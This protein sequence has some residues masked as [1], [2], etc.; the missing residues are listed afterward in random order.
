MKEN[1][2]R[3]LEWVFKDEGGYAEREEEGGGAVNMGITYSVFKAWRLLHGK[4][5]PTW[6]DLKNM[7]KAEATEIYHE[8]YLEDIH[9]DDLPAGVDYAVYD[10]SVNG[11][12][13]GSIKILQE[14][15]GLVV[16]GHYGLVTR[17]AVN[18][19]DVPTLINRLCDERLET[20]QTFKTWNTIANPKA[21]KEKQVTWGTIWSNRIA[22]VRKRAL[23]MALAQYGGSGF[24]APAPVAV[25]AHTVAAAPAPPFVPPAK[26]SETTVVI[27]DLTKAPPGQVTVKE[28]P[29]GDR[30]V[31][32]SD[33]AVVN[34][35]HGIYQENPDVVAEHIPS[36]GKLPAS[37]EI[38][39]GMIKHGYVVEEFLEYLES[40]VAKEFLKTVWRPRGVVL[41]NT[42]KINWPGVVNG[43]QITPEQRLDNMS[44]G[45][46]D[47]KFKAAPHLVLPPDGLVW[48]SWPLWKPG[49]HSPSWNSTYWGIEMVGDFRSEHPTAALLRTASMAM[50]GMYRLLGQQ[51]DNN[52]FKL[53]KED[54]KTSHKDCPGILCGP[55]DV[56]MMRI[57][58]AMEDLD[59]VGL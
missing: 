17:W 40:V 51:V 34:T 33:K 45:W 42:G 15:L 23:D 26:A 21:A 12:V 11:G 58:S 56:W 41:H 49:T 8:Q 16:D 6:E 25:P 13:T 52:H 22:V 38:S 14:A 47:A 35:K 50:A 44:V 1:L 3:V 39:K 10:A 37:T 20:Y 46:R 55:K 18:H 19:R 5:E 28:L 24:V 7:P 27:K 48:L 43:K 36:S 29:N 9:F 53:H 31:S 59:P 2:A 30:V 4:P 54:P 32:I 57:K